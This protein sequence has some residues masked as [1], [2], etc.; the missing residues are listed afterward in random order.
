MEKNYLQN[1]QFLCIIVS[2][3]IDNLLAKF[4]FMPNLKRATNKFNKI[5]KLKLI[6]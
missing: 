6:L 3:L 5:Y 2:F 4:Y 1:F